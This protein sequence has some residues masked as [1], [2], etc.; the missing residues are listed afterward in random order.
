MNT[1]K[2]TT[3]T[4]IET[5]HFLYIMGYSKVSGLLK[6]HAGDTIATGVEFSD[7]KLISNLISWEFRYF[8]QKQAFS[9]VL[10]MEI[11]FIHII[12]FV[13]SFCV[14]NELKNII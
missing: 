4:N 5:Y 13:F 12:L 1:A 3:I 8:N 2:P 11:K 10:I 6:H 14:M 7:L 9:S